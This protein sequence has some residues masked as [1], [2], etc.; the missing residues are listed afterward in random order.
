[1]SA[2]TQIDFSK[3]ETPAAS[4]QI[5][6]SKYEAPAGLPP[7]TISAQPKPTGVMD[8]I[9]KWTDNVAN[10]IKYGTDTTGV[11]TVLKKM[12]A[13]GVY[14]GN[15]QAVG[16]FMASLPLGLMRMAKGGAETNQPGKVIQGAK[17]IMAGAGQAA[18]M[19]SLADT[20]GAVDT[21]AGLAEAATKA[22][23]RIIEAASKIPSAVSELVGRS[24]PTEAANIAPAV[25]QLQPAL[26]ST[27]QE[28]IQYAAQKGI[29][30]TPAEASGKPVARTIQAVGER[31]L[32]GGDQLAEARQANAL[33]LAQN[34]RSIADAADPKGMGLTEEG[35]GEA[36]QQAAR[37]ARSVAHENATAAYD[38][39]GI[40]QANLAG[41]VSPLKDMA[42]KET[43][44][45]QPGAA[46]ARPEYKQPEVQSALNDIAS[47]PDQLGSNPSIQSMRN[48]RTEFL[49]RSRTDPGEAQ[50]AAQRLYSNAAD[51]VD[52]QIMKAAQGTPFEDSFRDASQQWADL[53]QKYDTSGTVLNR[54]LSQR[55]PAT[56]T[57]SILNRGSANDIQILQNENMTPAIDALK[58]QTI[59]DIAN[60]GFRVN[61]DGLGGYSDSFLTQLFGQEAK[62]EL[63][64]NGELARRMGFQVNPSGTSNVLLGME[65]LS[66][67]PTRAMIPMGAAKASMPRPAASYL[68]P[69]SPAISN[70][71]Q[72]SRVPLSHIDDIADLQRAI[73]KLSKKDDSQ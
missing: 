38:Q 33:K 59:Q 10:D 25:G 1:M 22:P 50:T 12:G 64:L 24:V 69:G 6:F 57:R 61:G 13:H 18:T 31:S 40:D 62:K 19:P 70:I 3:Y 28:V 15:S 60:R 8:S 21:A 16:D 68:T 4:P 47:K 43:M 37:T 11:G 23:G 36:I 26:A 42:Q 65:Q 44:V 55:D 41:D 72:L 52:S 7:S 34:V 63:Y 73:S 49:E 67:N 27:P 56:I 5:D 46:V 48:L 53:K 2:G 14:N 58:R 51:V 71:S 30:L 9:A 17:D 66:P 20:G 45:R 35:A 29:D 32:L 54:I 39:A